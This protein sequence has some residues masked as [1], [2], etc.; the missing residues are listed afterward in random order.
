MTTLSVYPSR[1]VRLLCETLRV[2]E[3][4]LTTREAAAALQIDRSTLSRWVT[5]YKLKPADVTLGG[6]RRW[7]LDDLRRQLAKI[8]GLEGD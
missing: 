2:T 8:K 4:Y 1:Y 7:D 3:R 5:K 6:H